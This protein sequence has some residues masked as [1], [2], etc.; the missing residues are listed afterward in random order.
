VSQARS[1]PITSFAE[2]LCKNASSCKKIGRCADSSRM[3]DFTPILRLTLLLALGLSANSQQLATGNL[4]LATAKSTDPDFARSVVLL[5]RYDSDSAIGLMLSKPT[6]V[7]ISEVLP[8]AKDHVK[9]RP[10]TVYAGGP[11][12]IG[13]RSLLRSKAPPFFAVVSNRSDLLR[14]VSSGLPPFRIFAGYTGWTAQQLQSEIARGLWKVLP[15][16]ASMVFDPRPETLWQRLTL[17]RPIR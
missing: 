13:V 16:S 4:L 12:T 5:I 9:L 6:K 15:A 10:V 11:V 17:P 8:E 3:N 2:F 7:P 14:M 1:R